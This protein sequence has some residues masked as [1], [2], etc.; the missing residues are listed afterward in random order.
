MLTTTTLSTVAKE[1]NTNTVFVLYTKCL[2]MSGEPVKM[3]QFTSHAVLNCQS[4]VGQFA[5]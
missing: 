3:Q 4:F 2:K 1:K 5:E